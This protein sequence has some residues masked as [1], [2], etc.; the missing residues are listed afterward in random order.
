MILDENINQLV[1]VDKKEY[2]NFKSDIIQHLYLRYILGIGDSGHHNIIIV[3]NRIQNIAG[4]D[5]EDF[6]GKISATNPYELLFKSASKE[7][8]NY[9]DI[10]KTLEYVNWDTMDELEK[11]FTKEHIEEFKKEI[12]ISK[13]SII[14]NQ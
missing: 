10:L 13:K 3:N 12:I 5:L 7:E 6:S 2:E 9:D 14:N 8:K 1:K 11:I 4:I